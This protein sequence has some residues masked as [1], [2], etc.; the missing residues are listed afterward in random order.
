MLDEGLCCISRSLLAVQ[1]VLNESVLKDKICYFKDRT[2][3][4][5]FVCTLKQKCHA[6][7]VGESIFVLA[8][9]MQRY[10]VV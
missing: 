6:A 3:N 2:D 5:F 4:Q 9:P 8:M 7:A 10:L 1:T